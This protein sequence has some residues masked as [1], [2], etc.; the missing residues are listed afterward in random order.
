MYVQ[1]K[2]R[3]KRKEGQKITEVFSGTYDKSLKTHS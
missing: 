2:Y 1:Q 3:P